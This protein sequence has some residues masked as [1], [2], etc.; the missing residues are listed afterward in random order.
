MLDLII[1]LSLIVA[2]GVLGFR[3]TEFLPQ[4]VL[5]QVSNVEGLRW[6]TCGFG[7]LIL[8][9]P[10]GLL[11][12][13]AYRRLEI[14]IQRLP[15]EVL[16]TRSVGLVL[17]LLLANLILA[18][19]FFLPVPSELSFLKPLAAILTSLTLGYVGTVAADTHGRAFLRLINPNAVEP[20]L[21]AEGTLR[22]ATTKILDTST[23]VD[24]RLE[25]ILGTGFLE[26]QL[27][28]PRFVLQELQYLADSGNEQRR[29]RGRR[30]LEL[31]NRLKQTYGERMMI[32][33]ADYDDGQPVDSKL[34]R[35]AQDIDGTL[36]TNDYN[37]NQVATVQRVTVLNVNELAQALRPVYL[38]GDNLDLKILREGKE[39]S[40]G[41]GYLDD[42][43]MV[44]VDQGRAFL[45]EEVGVVVTGALQTSAGRMIFARPRATLPTP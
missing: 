37:L 31:L 16:L 18:P 43:T 20:M 44:V 25:A 42:G 29:L 6:V 10:A 30:G 7:A 3:S 11:T 36:L 9:I 15:V 17:G 23:I 26:G 2:A 27:L 24:G 21:V 14:H 32:H 39:P 41:V 8:G 12:Q 5:G 38:P 19:L 33:P 45:G 1:V 22:P 34:I 13:G 28:I 4:D 40:Q 35:L